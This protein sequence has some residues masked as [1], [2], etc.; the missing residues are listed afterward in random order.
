MSLTTFWEPQILMIV[1]G[2]IAMITVLL[3]ATGA[4][5]LLDQQR[6]NLPAATRYSDLQ[7]RVKQETGRLEEITAELQERRSVLEEREQAQTEGEYWRGMAREAQADYESKEELIAE[8]DKLR[9][10]FTKE[11]ERLG[12]LRGEISELE[13]QKSVLARGL[14]IIEEAIKEHEDRKEEVTRLIDG[15][16][17]ARTRLDSLAD[18]IA[19]AERAGEELK[20]LLAQ[21]EHQQTLIERQRDELSKLERSIAS[22]EP[23]S[24]EIAQLEAKRNE[25]RQALADQQRESE[26]LDIRK[27]ELEARISVLEE[28]HGL[29]DPNKKMGEANVLEDL[30]RP[31]SSFILESEQG[32]RE[33]LLPNAAGPLTED[34][35]LDRVKQHLDALGLIFSSRTI[36]RLHTCLKSGT[37]SPLTL[38]A[39]ISGTGKSQLPQRYAEA[40]GIHF[41][42]IAVQ[43]RWD[44]PQDVLGFYNYLEGRYK[45]T[46]LARSLVHLDMFN[47]PKIASEFKDRLLLVLLDE[48]N[49]ARVEYY[50]SEFLSRL[51]GRPR[52]GT[53]TAE[54]R[55]HSEIEIDIRRGGEQSSLRIYPGHNLLFV[56]TMN[57]DESTQSLS[58]KVLDRSNVLRFSRPKELSS[59]T[60]GSSDLA[61]R[62]YLPETQWRSWIKGA[63]DLSNITTTML[64]DTIE[65]LNMQL[66]R[67]ER[68][69]GH[70]VNQAIVHYVANYPNVESGDRDKMAL[71]DQME[72]RILPKLRGIEIDK[73]S[74][75]AFREIERLVREQMDDGDLA[76][77]I[78]RAAIG[79][80]SGLFYWTGVRRDEA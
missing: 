24:E 78:K 11:S 74:S 57:E 68:P 25:S 26:A 15:E 40:L 31:P 27:G 36:D 61:S 55:V 45:A 5:L 7:E 13:T 65:E 76:E 49:L 38:L 56:G 48:M 12:M 16:R 19:T 72:L 58:D 79:G 59:A 75:G 39:G 43:P 69:F 64:N 80:P 66:E 20:E 67:I 23:R 51:E 33:K 14:E 1:G 34:A 2:G 29:L 30:T 17:E 62:D 44:S 50:F 60:L 77:A 63:S 37:I 10:E 71:A 52:P 47:W 53:E 70:R 22:L 73:E 42:K 21:S 4:T 46:D 54:N 6:R 18:Q 28:K 3:A 9:G 8:M 32:G 35:A 41:L